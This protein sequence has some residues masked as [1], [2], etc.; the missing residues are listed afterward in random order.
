MLLLLEA[1]DHCQHTPEANH[2]TNIMKS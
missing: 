2:I 1:L